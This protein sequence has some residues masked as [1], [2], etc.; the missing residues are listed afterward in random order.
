MFVN[1]SA[2][3]A[4]MCIVMHLHRACLQELEGALV[5]LASLGMVLEQVRVHALVQLAQLGPEARGCCC[6]AMH[7]PPWGAG[8]AQHCM[9][10]SVSAE[11][12]MHMVLLST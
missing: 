8:S 12:T 4:S 5:G 3:V 6:F 10:A 9:V 2:C 11:R 7:L 1:A